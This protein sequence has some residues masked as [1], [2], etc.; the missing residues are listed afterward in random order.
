M[1]IREISSK[2]EFI[3]PFMVSTKHKK[4]NKSRSK[5]EKAPKDC[6]DNVEDNRQ[7]S[8]KRSCQKEMRISPYCISCPLKFCRR[9]RI[10]IYIFQK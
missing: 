9:G 10:S 3:V 7:I 1:R 2:I 8:K 4:F 5:S 6:T